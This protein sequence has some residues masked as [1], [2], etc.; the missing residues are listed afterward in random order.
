[1]CRLGIFFGGGVRF[2]NIFFHP[3]Q[4]IQYP[5]SSHFQSMNPQILKWR[6]V[7]NN[8]P[9][10]VL[11]FNSSLFVFNQIGDRLAPYFKPDSNLVKTRRD[12]HRSP[13]SQRRNSQ[14]QGFHVNCVSL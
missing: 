1:M 10:S 14:F 12:Y 7:I 5:S 9:Q 13:V 6:D 4:C 2:L 3:I 8:Y 11:H